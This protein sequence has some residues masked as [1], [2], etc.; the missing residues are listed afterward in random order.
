MQSQPVLPAPCWQQCH[1]SCRFVITHSVHPAPFPGKR[2]IGIWSL[3]QF[4]MCIVLPCCTATQT[5]FVTGVYVS[6][7]PLLHGPKKE[8][9]GYACTRGCMQALYLLLHDLGKKYFRV[10]FMEPCCDL[11][12]KRPQQPV[13][14]D[15]PRLVTAWT[16]ATNAR[17]CVVACW[18]HFGS[19]KHKTRM[20]SLPLMC[21]GCTVN[22]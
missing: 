2:E 20:G 5:K 21:L 8:T 14:V 11:K 6:L 13:Q 18:V 4:S 9:R 12:W 7:Y 16:A 15:G 19:N 10:G 17:L 22:V 1:S 3:P